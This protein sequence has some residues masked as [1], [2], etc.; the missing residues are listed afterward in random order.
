MLRQLSQKHI[1]ILAMLVLGLVFSVA[2][3]EDDSLRI[4]TIRNL[5]VDS[6]LTLTTDTLSAAPKDSL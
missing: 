5:E 1:K 6:N 3:A 2:L 4:D